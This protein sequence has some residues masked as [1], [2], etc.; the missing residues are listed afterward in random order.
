MNVV[1]ITW[2]EGLSAVYPSQVLRPMS[3]VANRTGARIDLVVGSPLGEFLR[4]RGRRAWRDRQAMAEQEYGL[5]IV[6]IPTTPS[7]LRGLVPDR[8]IAS[9]WVR[10]MG[11][12]GEAVVL[13]CRGRAA[14]ELGLAVR[15]THPDSRVI[16]DCRGWEGPELLHARGF[17]GED[18]APGELLAASRR[19]EKSQRA[20]A[21]AADA[22]VVVSAAMRQVALGQW[23]VEEDRLTVVP[24]CT[25]TKAQAGEARESVRT[26]LGFDG[27]FVVVYCGSLARYQAI[28]ASLDVFEAVRRLRGDALFFGITPATARLT[29]LVRER[30][31][32]ESDYR[33]VAAP[34][35]EVSAL[36]AAGDLALLLRERSKV[37]EV[38]SPV[39]FAE[40][41]AA[42]LPVVVSE[43]IGDYSGLVRREGIGCVVAAPPVLPETCAM[44]EPYFEAH[45]DS[46]V[47]VRQRCRSVAERELS[48]EHAADSIAGL[49]RALWRD[50]AGSEAGE[51]SV[52]T[53]R[54]AA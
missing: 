27:R 35:P 40:Y 36:L 29:A 19:L 21:L 37:N 13:H 43:G 16:F 14:A 25:A 7:R 5:D 52:A 9:R 23:G 6:R 50:M 51:K 26:R 24:C 54:Q 45:R 17:A 48:A 53:V 20:V 15:A 33:I 46:A 38:A 28:D 41:L 31:W 47:A 1:H 30:G 18:G 2:N 32:P 34:H 39:K 22:V 8:A 11:R 4:S 10:A 3:L 49:Y 12:P 42:G 44:L